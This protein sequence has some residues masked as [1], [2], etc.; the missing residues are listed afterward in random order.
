MLSCNELD[1]EAANGDT[2]ENPYDGTA[3]STTTEST[4]TR[5]EETDDNLEFLFDSRVP[6]PLF[7][8]ERFARFCVIVLIVQI[9]KYQKLSD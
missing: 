2:E 6:S 3:P 8:K 7:L 9:Y 5:I 1:E 4:N